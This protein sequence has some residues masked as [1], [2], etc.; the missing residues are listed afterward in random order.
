[1]EDSRRTLQQG[2]T[3]ERM[4]M[5][6]KKGMPISINDQVGSS[7]SNVEDANSNR[8]TERGERQTIEKE[9]YGGRSI[10]RGSKIN[11]RQRCVR[12]TRQSEGDD[13]ANAECERLER[14]SEQK[15]HHR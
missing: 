3:K 2:T 5:K 9:S 11:G 7:E 4:K 13:V 12:E 10:E 1:M 8:S 15:F 6:L 14:L